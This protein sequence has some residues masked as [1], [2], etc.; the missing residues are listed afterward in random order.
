[1]FDGLVLFYQKTN[2]LEILQKYRGLG[3][4]GRF[5]RYRY[6]SGAFTFPEFRFS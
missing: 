5:L 2:S 4:R 3:D 6:R 1:M